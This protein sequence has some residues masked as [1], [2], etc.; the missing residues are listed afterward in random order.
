MNHSI[1]LQSNT[2]ILL[3]VYISSAYCLHSIAKRYQIPVSDPK[4]I[5]QSDE[6]SVR[7]NI[8]DRFHIN[9]NT[10][11]RTHDSRALGAKYLNETELSS[12]EDCL[13]WC[14]QTSPCNLAVYEQK[15]C[16]PTIVSNILLIISINCRLA[17]VVIC[18]T[19][20]LMKTFAVNSLLITSTR[21]LYS[22]LI[23][24]PMI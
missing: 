15:V 3:L 23:D 14:W 19:A 12:N 6:R 4:N 17:A 21:V 11:I 10:I 22:K 5:P 24:I 2:L 1:G 8:L 9:A 16:F 7:D 18:L 13:Y 20:D